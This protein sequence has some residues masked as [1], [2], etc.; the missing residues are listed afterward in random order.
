VNCSSR[1]VGRDFTSFIVI[2]SNRLSLFHFKSIFITASS[3]DMRANILSLAFGLAFAT[4][5]YALPA[6]DAGL[7]AFLS[8]RAVSPDNTCGN[9]YAGSNKSYTCDATVNTGGCCSQYGE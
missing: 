6:E 2:R 5:C 4:L 9:V 7:Y 1:L 8:K 3:K